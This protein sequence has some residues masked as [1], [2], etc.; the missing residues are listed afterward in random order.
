MPNTVNHV[1]WNRVSD[2][3][4]NLDDQRLVKKHI[5]EAL[6]A[7][8]KYT[9]LVVSR[10]KLE[11]LKH[12]KIGTTRIENLASQIEQGH[13]RNEK[14]IVYIVANN[15]S[16]I[17]NQI[18][19]LKHNIFIKDKTIKSHLKSA[20]RIQLY[21]ELC[22][23]IVKPVW[24]REKENSRRSRQYLYSKYKNNKNKNKSITVKE[25]EIVVSVK[26]SM[27]ESARSEFISNQDDP[28]C[29][30]V[31]L[32]ENEKAFLKLPQSLT[33]HSSFDRLKLLTDVALMGSKIR[34]TIKDRIDQGLSEHEIN[35]RSHQQKREEAIESALITRVY[36]PQANQA[37]FSKMRVT[38]M[39]TCRRV[40]IPDPLPE[41]EEAAIQS[42]ITAVEGAIQREAQ[43]NSKLRIKP[44]TLTKS[45]QLGL[46]SLRKRT[47]AGEAA[48][49]ATDKSGRLAVMSKEEY[50]RK[51]SEHTANDPIV[52]DSDVQVMEQILSCTASSLAKC[53][54]ISETWNQSDR[55]QSAVKAS[56][57]GVPPLAILL[58]DHKPGADKPVRP[59]CRSAQS[60]NGPLSQITAEVMNI[61][62]SDLN[63][64]THTEVKSTEEMCAVLDGVN[65]VVQPDDYCLLQCGVVEQAQLAK[66]MIETH[67][68]THPSHLHRL[69]GC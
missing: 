36:D 27:T 66:H 32:D 6:K 3:T 2:I 25:G 20:W 17:I 53:L 41:K 34:M 56:N 37:D 18:G 12:N 50:Q 49:V 39:K 68:R 51:V 44:S 24:D 67:P 65:D 28:V 38:S 11:Y 35:S 19:E 45:E 43:R 26:E 48:I 62:A 40:K 55:V 22:E 58:K 42:V 23:F 13:C 64:Q 63:K 57:T 9:K 14:T 61:I 10:D 29:V 60:P 33:N 21:K 47:K 1:A 31:T 8:M 69:D 52:N 59:L 5:E 4:N 16:Q 15:L 54:K 30:G 7:K 46:K